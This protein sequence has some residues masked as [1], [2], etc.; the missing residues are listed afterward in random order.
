VSSKNIL[1]TIVLTA[2][3]A[4]FIRVYLPIGSSFMNLQFPYFPSYIVLFIA[5]TRLG[6]YVKD[7]RE[8]GVLKGIIKNGIVE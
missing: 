1:L 5:G 6:E 7:E 8:E 3:T 2:L 4:F